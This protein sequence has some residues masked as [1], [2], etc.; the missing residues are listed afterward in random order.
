[1]PAHAGPIFHEDFGQI[2]QTHCFLNWV[3]FSYFILMLLFYW[4]LTFLF[5]YHHSYSTLIA[6]IHLC[7]A[8]QS[9]K[10]INSSC[11]FVPGEHAVVAAIIY[12]MV[13]NYSLL[14]VKNMLELKLLVAALHIIITPLG[15]FFIK[16][17]SH[18]RLSTASNN[19]W[20][21]Q[22]HVFLLHLICLWSNELWSILWS[23]KLVYR[24]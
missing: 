13:L 21:L 8:I 11:R 10:H 5:Y 3:V 16:I 18:N 20:I 4:L 12:V 14:K 6:F 22:S 17:A 1:M 9:S 19:T 24:S 2:F 7:A 15:I 23:W